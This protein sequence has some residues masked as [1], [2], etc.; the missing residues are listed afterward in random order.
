MKTIL[1]FILISF[2]C[3]AQSLYNAKASNK[4]SYV[5]Q[6]SFTISFSK[7]LYGLTFNQ[8]D[9]K[10]NNDLKT[11]IEQFMKN[12]NRPKFKG[13]GKF[14]LNIIKRNNR[15]YVVES[16]KPEKLLEL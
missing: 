10:L 15:Y 8:N 11:K 1:L 16:R 13:Q 4:V 3:T 12:T 14:T 2:N 7:S 6:E 9:R 5:N